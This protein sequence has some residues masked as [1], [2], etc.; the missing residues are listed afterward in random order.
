LLVNLRRNKFV[1][2]P[3][4]GDFDSLSAKVFLSQRA[5]LLNYY[6]VPLPDPLANNVLENENLDSK[7]SCKAP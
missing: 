5:D 7:E 3:V 6:I 4:A 2:A 1:A